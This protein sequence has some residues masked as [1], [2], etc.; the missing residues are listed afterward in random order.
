[1]VQSIACSVCAAGAV[2]LFFKP[3][4]PPVT[5]DGDTTCPPVPLVKTASS[6]EP[7]KGEQ[8]IAAIDLPQVPGYEILEELGRGGMGAVYKAR[9]VKLNRIVALKMILSG[10]HAGSDQ[11]ERFRTEAE[12]VARLQHPNILQIFEVGEC[13]GLPFLSL[14]FLDGG[15]LSDDLDG[16]PWPT[17][18]AARLVE[19]L[20]QAIH[21]AHEHNVVHRD[22]KPGNVLL[23]HERV[24]KIADFGLAK[25]LDTDAQQTRSGAILGTPSYMAPEQAGGKPEQIGPPVDI[26]ALGAILYE[27]LTGRPPFKAETPLDTIFQVLDDSPVPPCQLRPKLPRDL[28]TICLTCLRKAPRLR[29]AS[30]LALAEDLRLFLKGKAI[31][32]RR[33]GPWETVW[34][35]MKRN[36]AITF[37]MVVISLAGAIGIEEGWR[38]HLQYSQL[39]GNLNTRSE[40]LKKSSDPSLHAATT[41]A[42]KELP[43]ALPLAANLSHHVVGHGGRVLTMAFGPDSQRL[44]VAGADRMIRLYDVAQTNAFRVLE[45]HEEDVS[46]VTFHPDGRQLASASWDRTVRLWDIENGRQQRTL[47]SHTRRAN[48]VAFSPDGRLLA[49]G[50]A[51]ETIR[52]F[53]TDTG[54]E[55]RV[56]P[57]NRAVNSIAFSPQGGLLVAA[58]EAGGVQIWDVVNGR[59]MGRLTDGVRQYS[60]VCFSADGKSVAAAGS[61]RC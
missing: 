20:A 27:L 55:I 10:E 29:Y 23:T 2:T 44:A 21:A 48:C 54:K 38:A 17:R 36:R 60:S 32:A 19:D 58:T 5:L 26:Y 46:S 50:G 30:A 11:L 16:T 33:M 15:S 31:L 34:R 45:G 7:D 52:L 59:P 56:L 47:K 43:P 14:E 25:R 3:P 13:D 6:S 9:Q 39:M 51:D 57:E 8:Y 22:L 35:D 40:Q 28:E 49:S 12:V 42:K 61:V 53:E 41:E 4:A 37:T 1:V 18:A 24:P